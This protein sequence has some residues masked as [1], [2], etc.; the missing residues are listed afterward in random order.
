MDEKCTR[1][2]AS[3]HWINVFK[4]G[5]ER[6]CGNCFSRENGIIIDAKE[7]YE[8]QKR[9]EKACDDSWEKRDQ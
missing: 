2:Q 3:M 5:N 9:I 1:C 7:R 4:I 8:K 6:M